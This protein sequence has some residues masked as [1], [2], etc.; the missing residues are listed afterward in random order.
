MSFSLYSQYQNSSYFYS[1]THKFFCLLFR[2]EAEKAVDFIPLAF[3]MEWPFSFKT[4]PGKS[5]L[6]QVCY[7]I[8]ICYLFQISELSR[9]PGPLTILLKHPKVRCHGVN[10]KKYFS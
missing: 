6:I 3:D 1:N 8:N 10:I 7:D 2:G 5:A 4:G 9:L